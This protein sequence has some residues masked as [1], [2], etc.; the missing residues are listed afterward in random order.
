MNAQSAPVVIN[1]DLSAA[2]PDAAIP[3]AQPDVAAV[4]GSPQPPPTAQS[5]PQPLPTAEG[6][7]AFSLQAAEE[8]QQAWDL[9]QSPT[10]AGLDL[11]PWSR[12]RHR[13]AL[14]LLAADV[15][16]YDL[17][18]L[19]RVQGRLVE[20]ARQNNLPKVP[21]L[22]EADIDLRLY[23]PSAEKV[24]FLAAH[25][26]EQFLHLRPSLSKF[27]DVITEWGAAT[28]A[29]DQYEEACLCALRL[30]TQHEKSV[31]MHQPN[32][33]HGKTDLGN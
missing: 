4:P 29:P 18:T 24:L 28:I 32:R 15:S 27:L 14:Q 31:P 26:P 25:Q 11:Y 23:L 2:P 16:V 20:I 13:L 12:E 8:R 5:A 9:A 10:F 21:T 1:P 22:A 19:S 3:F 33:K 17:D 30:M 7:T 6:E